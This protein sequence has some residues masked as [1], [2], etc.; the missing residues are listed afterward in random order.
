MTT[1]LWFRLDLRVADNL[2]F[3][4]AAEHGDA[5]IPVYLHAPTEEGDWRAGAASSWW[6]HHSLERLA[7]DLRGLGSRLIVR[8]CEDSL[9]ELL[10]LAHDSGA[11]RVVWNR[12]YEPAV[13]ARDQMIKTALRGA[14]I[15]AESFNGGLLHEPWSARTKTGTAFQVF[16]PYWRQCSTLPDPSPPSAAPT[17]LVPAQPWPRSEPLAS[18]G[19]LPRKNW[20][21]GFSAAWKP[22]SQAGHRLLAEFLDQHFD[23]YPSMRDH[24]GVDG[25]SRLSPY[26]HFGE[27]SAREIWHAT[28]RFAVNRGQH[29]TWRDSRFLT[30]IGWREFAY[31]LL[32]HFPQTPL[33]PLHERYSRMP[34]QTETAALAA[35]KRGQTGYPIVDAGMRQLWQT[36]WMHNRARMI[37]GSFLVKDLLIDWTQGARWF[38]DTLVDADLASNTLGWQW[39]AG[40][41][42]DASPF[43]RIFNPS[44]QGAKFD[45]SGDYVRRWVPELT[46]L[47][48][49]WIHKPWDAPADVLRAAKVGLGQNYPRPLV[50]HDAARQRALGAL[51]KMKSAASKAAPRPNV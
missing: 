50:D 15:E 28:Q 10:A 9:L 41:G 14:G 38:W 32:Y 19:L 17:R 20:A 3:C 24:P 27:L 40:C 1:L 48:D 36:G 26:L 47:P 13:M 11:K 18:L 23:A 49:V 8:R 43:F 5:V 51:A 42:A 31:H 46:A 45:A 7:E 6:L 16:T 21:A 12:R 29:T 2:A 35:W 30:E 34:W 22:G 4:A 37:A 25:T 39:V 44:L 33:Q